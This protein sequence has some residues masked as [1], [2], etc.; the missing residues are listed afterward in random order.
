MEQRQTYLAWGLIPLGIAS[1]LLFNALGAIPAGLY[2]LIVRASPVVILLIGLILL[3]R[4]RVPLGGLVALV[5]SLALVGGIAS[6]AYSSRAKQ[7]RTE[8]EINFEQVI[9]DDMTLLVINIDVHQTHLTL[10]SRPDNQRIVN[11][12]YIGGEESNLD[13]QFDDSASPTVE[14]TIIET[15]SEQFPRLTAVGRGNIT[16]DVPS[17]IAIALN[18]VVDEG[19]TTL[20]LSDLQL[21]RITLDIKRGDAAVNLPNYQPVSLNPAE[22]PNELTL[23]NGNLTLLAP[24]EIDTRIQFDRRG[25][26][27]PVQYDSLYI[28][29][30]DT[31]DGIL[32][33]E[34]ESSD[35]RLYFEVLIPRGQ[36]RLDV[37]QD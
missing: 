22:R 29:Q 11:G 32:R 8:K 1:I 34:I 2:D 37:I 4:G 18:I 23:L 30:R 16:V 14:Y 35:V 9:D 26:G 13:I 33:R 10:R 27:I 12:I 21:E 24:N 36:L 6:Y 31:V 7:E 28:D 5:I 15:K 25:S 19:L 17:N 20:S 3:L